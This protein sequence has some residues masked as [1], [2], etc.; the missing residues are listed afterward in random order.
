MQLTGGVY[1]QRLGGGVLRN[2]LSVWGAFDIV[3]RSLWRVKVLMVPEVRIVFY[4]QIYFTGIE[5]LGK[6]SLIGVLLGIVIFTQVT[7]I[8]G[9]NPLLIGKILVWTVVRE[10]GPL[11]AAILIIARSST[12]ITSELG[13]M[14]VRGEVDSLRMMGISPLEYL[15]VPRLAG[16]V[17]SV[18]II[19]FYFQIATIF[20]GL[21]FSSFINHTAIMPVLR[22]IFDVVGL[23]E[24]FIAFIKSMVFGMIIMSV[25]C[26]HGLRVRDSINQIPRATSAAV[27][28]G[29]TLVIVF[30]GLITLSTFV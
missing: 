13:S 15:V 11:F 3:R 26:F 6:A 12:A 20:G 2:V 24:I 10:L 27:V 25:S 14:S 29:L 30:D 1:L 23:F 5:A 8:V 16:G 18:I 28:Q 9:T 17:L 22:G 4:R 21:V 19:T 7:N